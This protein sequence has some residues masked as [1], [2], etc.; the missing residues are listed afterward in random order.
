[1][2]E[3]DADG[4]TLNMIDVIAEEVDAFQAKIIEHCQQMA[5]EGLTRLAKRAKESSDLI[6]SIE[7]GIKRSETNGAELIANLNVLIEENYQSE[8]LRWDFL[9]NFYYFFLITLLKNKIHF[10]RQNN[11]TRGATDGNRGDVERV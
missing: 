2:Y 10:K 3:E 8:D 4:R 11:R 7:N 9:N 1:M 5:G 6:G